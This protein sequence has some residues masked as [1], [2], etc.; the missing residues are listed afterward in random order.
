MNKLGVAGPAVLFPFYIAMLVVVGGG[1]AVSLFAFF[2]GGYDFRVEESMILLDHVRECLESGE[3]FRDGVE[4]DFDIYINCDLNENALKKSLILVKDVQ[5]GHVLFWGVRDYETQC[6][7][8]GDNFP[9]CR[10][11]EAKFEGKVYEIIVGSN[12]YAR[13]I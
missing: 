10:E 1:I 4:G 2:G 13:K 9:K 6:N 8:K 5:N 12:Q 7:L 11:G 3:M